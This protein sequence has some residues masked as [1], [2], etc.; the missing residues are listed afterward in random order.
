MHVYRNITVHSLNYFVCN[1]NN[2][3]CICP[4][5]FVWVCICTCEYVNNMFQECMNP[6][7]HTTAIWKLCLPL[8]NKSTWDN[9]IHNVFQV[10]VTYTPSAIF[11]TWYKWRQKLLNVLYTRR[12]LKDVKYLIS[13]VR[14]VDAVHFMSN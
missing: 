11:C 5:W 10:L 4:K 7:E 2:V 9:D 8:S 13:W 12:L 3:R 1:N 14:E 6:K